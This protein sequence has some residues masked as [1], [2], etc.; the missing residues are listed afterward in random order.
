MAIKVSTNFPKLI[1]YNVKTTLDFVLIFYAYFI[2][3]PFGLAGIIG[4]PIAAG[5]FVA[6]PVGVLIFFTKRK[7]KKTAENRR[8]IRSED[9]GLPPITPLT[10]LKLSVV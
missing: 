1:P 5:I 8:T 7:N 6:V 9:S 4:I 3:L 10:G 2:A